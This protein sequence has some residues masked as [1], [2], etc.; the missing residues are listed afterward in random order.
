MNERA[1]CGEIKRFNLGRDEGIRAIFTSRKSHFKKREAL[2]LSLFREMTQD[3]M[4]DVPRKI[5]AHSE[6]A[7]SKAEGCLQPKRPPYKLLEE[8]QQ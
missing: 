3:Q 4:V 6:E 2:S 8:S 7:S 5:W 1:K